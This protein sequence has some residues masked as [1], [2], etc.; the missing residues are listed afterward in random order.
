ADVVLVDDPASA[1]QIQRYVDKVKSGSLGALVVGF[2]PLQLIESLDDRSY[3]SLLHQCGAHEY[4]M[5]SCYRQKAEV[6]VQAKHVA[7]AVAASSPFLHENKKAEY[8]ADRLRLT[9]I[10]NDLAYPNPSGYAR[11]FEHATLSDWRQYLAWI[12]HQQLW[13]HWSPLLIVVD[14][15][16]AFPD[17]WAR[18]TAGIRHEVVTMR[19]VASIKGLEYQHVALLITA[20]QY[21]DVASG[22]SGSGRSLYDQYRLIRIPFSRAKDSMV[23]FVPALRGS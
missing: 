6:G 13:T 19:D 7:D 22:F 8:A 1:S 9:T 23:T 14:E 16:A 2:D 18:E 11:T 3:Q 4:A 20:K 5:T 12:K 17:T 21:A 15:N 10:A